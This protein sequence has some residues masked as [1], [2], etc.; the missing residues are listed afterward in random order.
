[1]YT[2]TVCGAV[3]FVKQTLLQQHAFGEMVHGP[4]AFLNVRGVMYVIKYNDYKI[5]FFW[6][7]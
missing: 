2:F 7:S 1:V 6:H 3:M 5:Q 4:L